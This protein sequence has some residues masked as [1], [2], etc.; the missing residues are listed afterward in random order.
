MS[1][2]KQASGR[3]IESTGIMTRI[4]ARGHGICTPAGITHAGGS[5]QI[6]T[7]DASHA[8]QGRKS[9]LFRPSALFPGRATA[10]SSDRGAIGIGIGIAIGIAVER[11]RFSRKSL[12]CAASW[13]EGDRDADLRPR[14]R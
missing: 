9:R 14:S 8:N 1:V 10:K 3:Q 13:K 4:A 5:P 7:S 6:G 12:L 2:A 11:I